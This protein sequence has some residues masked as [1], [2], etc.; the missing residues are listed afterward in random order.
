MTGSN[1]RAP[2]SKPCAWSHLGTGPTSKPTLRCYIGY[3]GWNRTKGEL[4]ILRNA[5]TA[6]IA[7]VGFTPGTRKVEQVSQKIIPEK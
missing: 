7:E 4:R 2:K 5:K 6:Q 1:L 3:S